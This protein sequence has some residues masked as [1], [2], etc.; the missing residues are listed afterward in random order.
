MMSAAGLAVAGH[1]PGWPSPD[2]RL[3]AVTATV[4]P[5]VVMQMQIGRCRTY[6]VRG[7]NDPT[8]NEL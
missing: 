4:L 1:W 6:E 8:S 3:L 7:H 5:V 2:C